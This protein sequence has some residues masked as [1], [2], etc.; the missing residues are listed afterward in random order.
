MVTDV[1][2]VQTF[3]QAVPSSE[4]VWRAVPFVL[5][6]A[7][8]QL[9]LM[10]VVPGK[11][12]DGPVAPSGHVPKY[13]A[14]GVQCFLLTILVWAVGSY[15]GLIPAGWQYD[16]ANGMFA[17]LNVSSIC[18]CML[19]YLKGRFLPSTADSGHSGNLIFDF[20]WGTELYPRFGHWIW[21]I[22]WDVKLFTNCRFGM[23]YWGI[24]TLSYAAKQYE[25]HGFVSDSMLVSS[26]VQVVYVLKFFWWEMGYMNTMDIQHDRAGFYICWGCLVWVP[27]LYTCHTLF[28]V[29][30]PYTMGRT[31][32]ALLLLFGLLGVWINYES[33]AQ[34]MR[35]RRSGGKCLIWGKPAKKIVAS[36]TTK[37]GVK[38]ESLLLLSGWWGVSRHFHYI[39]E[40]MAAF[41]WTAPT[42]WEG[43]WAGSST[44]RAGAST[45]SLCHTRSSRTSSRRGEEEEDRA[46]AGREGGPTVDEVMAMD[47]TDVTS[48]P[49]VMRGRAVERCVV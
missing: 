15:Q 16:H 31:V 41:A 4:E 27:S 33:D 26:L 23:M 29:N 22:G 9:L 30:N 43:S 12:V 40:L 39:P 45:A 13:K 8:F 7:A 5:S 46:R 49:L 44:E 21:P 11:Y 6:F 17:F 32:T 24:S 25:L 35:F 14:N 3:S 20:F 48:A 37:D 34:K 10:W 2:I 36:Y 42:L 38:K 28:L 18:L 19:L 47:G 1:G